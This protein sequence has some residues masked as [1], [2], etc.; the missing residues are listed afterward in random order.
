Y[1]LSAQIV[2]SGTGSG[3]L[4]LGPGDRST[5]G[6]GSVYFSAGSNVRSDLVIVPAGSDG[7][8]LLV[9]NSPDAVQVILDVEGW[10]ND[11]GP[12]VPMVTSGSF[13][14][15]QLDAVPDAAASFTFAAPAG[16]S[17]TAA[18]QFSY[19][20]D[21]AE[22]TTI[23]A[24][25]PTVQ[26]PVTADGPH[27]LVVVAIDAAG[28]QSEPADFH[29]EIGQDAPATPPE[30]ATAQVTIATTETTTAEDGTTSTESSYATAQPAQLPGGEPPPTP[31][32][33]CRH[34][35][36]GYF[37]GAILDL[38]NNCRYQVGN[39]AIRLTPPP[40][41]STNVSGVADSG[42]VW[43]LDGKRRGD[44]A[45][46]Y[47]EEGLTPEYIFHGTFGKMPNGSHVWGTDRLAFSYVT[48]R[49][50]HLKKVVVS[51]DFLAV[52]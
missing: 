19:G 15:G 6:V 29:F 28:V 7:T 37:S 17:N 42:F 39:F 52:P 3:Y 14:D 45:K 47:P 21:D 5:P 1:A 51:V 22:P 49:V 44:T 16:M 4:A 31:R 32:L 20:L 10:F 2:H 8:V 25:S 48:G 12:A 24:S 46:H 41:G 26:I 50:F 9:N 40:P 34:D 33:S 27:D 13:S 38:R 18:R 35:Y 43:Y 11:I 30:D 23:D 36:R